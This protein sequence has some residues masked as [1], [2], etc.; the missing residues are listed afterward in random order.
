LLRQLNLHP[1]RERGQSFL[2]DETVLDKILG[3]AEITPDDTVLEVGPGFGILTTELARRA[4]RV[5]AV[6]LDG[7]L[8]D[9]LRKVLAP[10]QN[11]EL[12]QGDI[13]NVPWSALPTG[14]YKLVANIPYS[15]TSHLLRRFLEAPAPPTRIVVMVQK[16]VAER[17]VAQP[18]DM[19]VLAV[20]V[21]FYAEPD[22]VA[23]VPARSFYPVPAVASAI[24]RLQM[25]IRPVTDVPA[26]R[27]FRLVT[28]GFSQRRKQ[29][30]NSIA[31]G[32]QLA[33]DEATILLRS[34]G[35][36]EKRRA[37]TLT[38]AEWAALAREAPLK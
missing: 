2:V 27:F 28:A 10:F 30:R 21:Q 18:D 1:S 38:L 12:M 19:S 25:R 11:V 15:I 34:A 9:H 5:V 3:A 22:L 37:E 16:E 36:D 20:S 35:I 23:I 26:D 8:T 24:V 33:P 29:L 32:L 6:E 4:G 13:L 14:R 17:I 7:R 31:G